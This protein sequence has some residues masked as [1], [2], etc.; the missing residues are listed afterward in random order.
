MAEQGLLLRVGADVTDVTKSLNQV[1][2]E[3]KQLGA[4]IKKLSGQDL[5]N[6]NKRLEQLGQTA[7]ALKN[8]GRTGFDQFGAAISR[9]GA[10]AVGATPALNS[11]S[12]VARDLPFGFIAIQNNLPI[13][14]D[15]FTA[16]TRASGGIGGALRGVG[17]ALLGP[18]GL[19]FAF[20]AVTAVITGAIQKYGSLDAA[21]AELGS[22][23]DSTG[24]KQNKFNAGLDE[25]LANIQVE[26]DKVVVRFIK[27]RTS[28]CWVSDK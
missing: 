6:A 7:Q 28:D 3:I 16:L 12:Q 27:S 23:I 20:G 17:A 19:A 5:V 8:V 9:V 24:A 22:T 21:L 14:V 2:A 13:V 11:L 15:Q 25:A 1:E 4:E 18:A 10:S 26:S